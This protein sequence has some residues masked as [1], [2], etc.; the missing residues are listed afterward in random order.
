M[1]NLG[2]ITPLNL[3]VSLTYNQCANNTALPLWN[4]QGALRG[5][6]VYNNDFRINSGALSLIALANSSAAPVN[7]TLNTNV[8]WVG[9]VQGNILIDNVYLGAVAFFNT[10]AG[11]QGIL[12]LVFYIVFPFD[13]DKV[14]V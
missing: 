7:N 5:P 3:S 12:I 8:T 13:H 10:S 4:I 6:W 9:S 11:L 2:S 14:W 1:Y